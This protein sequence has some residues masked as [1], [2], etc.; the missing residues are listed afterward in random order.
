[1]TWGAK[2]AVIAG[3]GLF[4]GLTTA[5]WIGFGADVYAAYLGDLI[6]RCF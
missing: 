1:M 3:L 4:S 5:V 6:M 2:V